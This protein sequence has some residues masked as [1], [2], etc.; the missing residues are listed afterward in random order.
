VFIYQSTTF[1]VDGL[2]GSLI[3]VLVAGLCVYVATR[4]PRS[5]GVAVIAA[6]LAMNVKFTGVP[7]AAVLLGLAVPIVWW[8]HGLRVAFRMAAVAAAAGAVGVLLLGYAPYV[9]NVREQV[10]LFYPASP[11]PAGRPDNLAY[12]RPVN[13]TDGNR[14]TRFFVSSFSRSEAVRPPRATQ[15]KFPFWIGR[16]ERHGSYGADLEAGGFGPLYGALLLLA[17]AGAVALVAHPSTRHSGGMVLLLGS[18]LFLSMFVHS[19]TWWARFVPQAW[20]LPI[21]VAVPS[22]CSP[23]RSVQRWLGYGLV[24]LASANLLVV[25]ANVGWR[26]LV[27]ARATRRSLQEMSAARQP[28]TVYLGIFTP[29][30]RRL[31]EAGIRFR[32]VDTSPEPHDLRHTIPAPGNQT[33][34]VE[35][36]Q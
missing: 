17:G 25:G 18:C 31:T 35:A 32:T 24:V 26:Q 14:V 4:R 27:N 30:R 13:L 6:C 34:W 5:L 19:E 33:F 23:R 29:L 21:L 8:R 3:T 11:P 28:V 16:E 7:Y 12:Q 22:L 9:R 1:Y 10:G 20:L 36:R 2:L 15:L